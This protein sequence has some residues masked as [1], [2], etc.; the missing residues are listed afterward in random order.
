[1]RRFLVAA[2]LVAFAVAGVACAADPELKTDDDKTLYALGLV[3]SNQLAAFNLTPAELEIV[4]AGL[5]DGTL[6][7]PARVELDAYG[8]KI[9]PLVQQRRAVLT[10]EEKKKGKEFLEKI[11]AKEGCQRKADGLLMETITEGAGAGPG[12]SD[13]VKVNYRGTL[14]DGREFD[15]SYKSGKPA[16]FK[17]NE[18]LI[19]C[20][21]QAL[22]F[23]KPGGKA[24]VYCPS[25][26]AYK[27]RG[28]GADIP[29]GATLVFE[30]ELLAVEKQ[31]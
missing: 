13:K 30:I 8:P 26:I 15:S 9:Q 23:M 18:N 16:E 7:H 10:A 3:I 31:P 5:S 22:Q 14:I 2:A 27:D 28:S 29:P 6:K 1:M 12:P 25:D 4:K 21:T 11:A 20:W 24:K 17:L 19:P